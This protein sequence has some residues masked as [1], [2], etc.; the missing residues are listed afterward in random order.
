M[1]KLPKGEVDPKARPTQKRPWLKAKVDRPEGKEEEQREVI[2]EEE[3][4]EEEEDL[5]E[6]Q[7]RRPKKVVGADRSRD[8]RS[9]P[10]QTEG[11]RG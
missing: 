11:L 3:V 5:R 9:L 2:K 1:D 7:P 6:H 8:S 10:D 4:E